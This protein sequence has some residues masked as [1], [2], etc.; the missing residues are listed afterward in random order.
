MH[1][2]KQ[3]VCLFQFPATCFVKSSIESQCSTSNTMMQLTSSDFSN[4]AAQLISVTNG[5]TDHILP[6]LSLKIS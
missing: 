6:L 1:I 2:L 4:E 5:Q 3:D